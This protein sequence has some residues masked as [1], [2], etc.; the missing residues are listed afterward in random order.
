MIGFI[1]YYFAHSLLRVIIGGRRDG[2]PAV[3]EMSGD[4]KFPQNMPSLAKLYVF[5]GFHLVSFEF[6]WHFVL[7]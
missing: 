2:V 3:G 5:S 7:I 6:Q 1:K 4:L